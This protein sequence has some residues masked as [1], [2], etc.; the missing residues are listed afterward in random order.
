[1]TNLEMIQAEYYKAVAKHPHFCDTFLSK[2][3]GAK[4]LDVCLSILRHGLNLD[5]SAQRVLDIE[6]LEA[7]VEYN[8]GNL[9]ACLT[10]LAQCGAVI[11]RMMEFVRKEKEARQ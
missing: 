10:E 11:L 8:N 7:L 3:G 2:L 1:M 9:D 5:A 6:I 4:N